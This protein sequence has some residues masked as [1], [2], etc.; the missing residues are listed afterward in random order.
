MDISHPYEIETSESLY[1][2]NKNS[3]CNT[4]TE[5]V[6]TYCNLIK[7]SKK[8]LVFVLFLNM[9]FLS[10]FIYNYFY[11]GTELSFSSERILIEPLKANTVDVAVPWHIK[12]DQTLNVD[13]IDTSSIQSHK[14]DIIK[15]VILS[16]RKTGT[17]ETISNNELSSEYMHYNGWKGAL[18][19]AAEKQTQFFIP[20]NF[21]VIQ[22]TD[23][24]GDINIRLLH[25]KSDDGNLGYTK[26]QT[27]N[28][29]IVKATI[30][31]YDVDGLSDSEFS[32][33]IKHEF[34]HAL[35]LGHS[36]DHNDLMHDTIETRYSYISNC[37]ISAIQGLYDN[38]QYS[39]TICH[40]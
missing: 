39:E 13:I 40:V 35:G 17:T 23:P 29:Q 4:V 10:I 34:G 6:R 26:L 21:N 22:S 9:M 28:N 20:V 19:K 18:K 33:I 14:I 37:D 25:Y 24:S 8:I 2:T 1:K 38:Q 15:D 27:D 32:S 12:I 5:T 11:Q 3:Y 36:T 7:S 30:T 16:E 31:I